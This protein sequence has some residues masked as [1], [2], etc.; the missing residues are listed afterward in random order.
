MIKAVILDADGMIVHGTRF[1]SRLAKRFGIS[2]EI[3]KEFFD[4]VFQDCVIGTADL[5]E[6]LPKYFSAWGWQGSL[7]EILEFWFSAEYNFIDERFAPL[8]VELRQ[9]GYYA[10]C[11]LA[12]NNE[13]YRTENLVEKR[14]LGRYF[15]GIF[16]SASLGCKKPK[17]E[18]FEKILE[19][20]PGV[21]KEEILFWDD[22]T[23]NIEGAKVFGLETQIYADFAEFKKRV[24]GLV[25]INLN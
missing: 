13:K 2:T 20:M 22:D 11:Y 18:F 10:K 6:E 5:K 7:D 9:K 15:D 21:K 19:S 3:T 23:E 1:S 24:E 17:P 14:G 8:V 4:G 16:S 12:T 25:R